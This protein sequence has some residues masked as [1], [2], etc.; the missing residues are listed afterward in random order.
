VR[1]A[2][3]YG[4]KLRGEGTDRGTEMN[5]LVAV[6]DSEFAY[7]IANFVAAHEW[8]A[9]SSF[10]LLHVLPS[11]LPVM[12]SLPSNVIEDLSE[13]QN[14]A[15]KRL[16]DRVASKIKKKGYLVD[17]E[18]SEG[19]AK[20]KILSWARKIDADVIVM[21]S[22]GRAGVERWILGNVSLS[23][24]SSAHCSVLIVRPPAPAKHE[25]RKTESKE[26][27]LV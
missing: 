6:D 9:D 18:I 26:K 3:L 21:G 10:V 24:A 11:L 1:R 17:Q 7:Y 25:T 12:A 14:Q 13:G 22:H 15:A 23:V 16:L 8:P 20:S 4:G 5:I 2:P 27:E 19:D